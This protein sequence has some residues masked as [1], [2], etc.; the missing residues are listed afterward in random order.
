MQNSS[1]QTTQTS[2]SMFNL[3]I[4]IIFIIL[5]KHYWYRKDDVQFAYSLSTTK[6]SEKF[7][8]YYDTASTLVQQSGEQDTAL[9]QFDMPCLIYY[10]IIE[11]LIYHFFL[12]LSEFDTSSFCHQICSRSFFFKFSLIF[13]SLQIMLF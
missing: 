4:F 7:S 1:V 11:N 8:I 6:K 3:L 12:L 2:K 10:L 13:F 9:Y 5:V